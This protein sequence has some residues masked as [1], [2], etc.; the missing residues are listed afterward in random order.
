[1]SFECFGLILESFKAML[2]KLLESFELVQLQ[3]L[4]EPGGAGG[5]HEKAHK[6]QVKSRK[7]RRASGGLAMYKHVAGRLPHAQPHDDEA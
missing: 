2:Q 3:V 6:V 5:I 7:L 1:M 4:M